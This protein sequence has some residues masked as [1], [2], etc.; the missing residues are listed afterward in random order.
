MKVIFLVLILLNVFIKWKVLATTNKT[1]NATVTE[2][3]ARFK[4]G[5]TIIPHPIKISIGGEDALL[6]RDRL[7]AVADGAGGEWD[8]IN[9]K[10]GKYARKIMKLAGRFYDESLLATPKKIMMKANKRTKINGSSTWLIAILDP[11]KQKVS[12]TMVG[13]SSYMIIRPQNSRGFQMIYRSFEQQRNFNKPL[14]I[15]F[16]GEKPEIGIDITHSINHND[17]IVM[18]SDGVFDNCFDEEIWE[19]VEKN[20]DRIGNMANPKKAAREIAK[21]AEKHGADEKWRS[22]LEINSE[23]NGIFRKGGKKDDISVIVSQIKLKNDKIS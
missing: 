23:K 12:T 4:S 10:A 22:P 3:Y 9:P 2:F 17:V 15:G 7:I 13:D 5:S 11:K 16:C 8:L 19:I 14:Q 6:V 21:L 1:D 18:G 20:L